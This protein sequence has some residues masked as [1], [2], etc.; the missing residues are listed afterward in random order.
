MVRGIVPN[1]ITLFFATAV[2][3]GICYDYSLFEGDLQIKAYGVWYVWSFYVIKSSSSS[4]TDVFWS[5]SIKDRHPSSGKS[6]ST[7]GSNT[8]QAQSQ[9]IQ[10]NVIKTMIIVCVFFAITWLPGNVYY[11]MLMLDENF[12]TIDWRYYVTMFVAFY[13]TSTNLRHQI[14][15][16]QK[17]PNAAFTPAQQV[18]RTSNLLRATSNMLRAS[19][20]LCWPQQVACYP[21]QVACC[22]QL[23]A[24]S[25]MLRATCNLLR[26]CK[27]GIR[28]MILCKKTAVQPDGPAT[29]TAR[30]SRR[31]QEVE[32]DDDQR[33]AG[34][35]V[36]REIF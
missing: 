36:T 21:Q 20:C 30:T 8:A 19:S 35:T 13:Y 33:R 6:N 34:N 12:T 26:W 10:A 31:G 23:V 18:A 1:T 27:R 25:N 29:T 15:S 4:A 9:Q 22:A 16:C 14:L 24:S 2:I 28:A 5:S 7:S 3:E 17:S 11:L 32:P